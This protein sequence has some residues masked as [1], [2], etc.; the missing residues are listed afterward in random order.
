MRL[1]C[2][3]MMNRMGR[4]CLSPLD[5]MLDN[6]LHCF[7]KVSEV[8]YAGCG[9]SCVWRREAFPLRKWMWI[10]ASVSSRTVRVWDIEGRSAWVL[11]HLLL[12]VARPSILAWVTILAKRSNIGGMH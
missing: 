4:Y 8:V 10:V 12:L 3:K 5:V 9:C 2:V 1:R 11:G 7:V 6:K